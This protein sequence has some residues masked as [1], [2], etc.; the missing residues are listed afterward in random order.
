MSSAASVAKDLAAL[1][2]PTKAKNSARFF[3]TGDGDYGAHDRFV[4]VTVPEQRIVA[5]RHAELA[6]AEIEKLLASPVHEERLTAL[7]I[8]VRQY[9]RGDDT[10][11]KRCFDCYLANLGG[12][13]NWD[14]VDSSAHQIVGEHLVARKRALLRRLAKSSN[15]WERRVAMV[16]TYA[17]IC[18]GESDE[19]F[20]IARLLLDD[21]HDLI[22]K[23]VGWMLREVGK[24]VSEAALREFL[25][26]HGPRMPR[27]ALRYAIER[28]SEVE[29]KRFLGR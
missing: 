22:H 20:A 23:A 7:L 9:E 11:R 10:T 14:L 13:N 28:F 25:R 17:F 19:T 29:R 4:G 16:A 12:V 26:T 21:E 24:R 2:N 27:T 1:G 18:R 3:K 8:L 15:L 5:R 6:L